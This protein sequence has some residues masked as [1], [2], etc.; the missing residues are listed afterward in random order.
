MYGGKRWGWDKG[1]RISLL[2]IFA[3]KRL[4]KESTPKQQESGRGI[5]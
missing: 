3:Q 1:S 4:E 2:R 5:N